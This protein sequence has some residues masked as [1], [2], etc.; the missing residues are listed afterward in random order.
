MTL[1]AGY[2]LAGLYADLIKDRPVDKNLYKDSVRW[3]R[4]QGGS[5]SEFT[6]FIDIVHMFVSNYNALRLS[7]AY[8]GVPYSE[9]Y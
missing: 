3:F 6:V 9:V 7:D 1:D 5:D 8:M 4:E 2:N